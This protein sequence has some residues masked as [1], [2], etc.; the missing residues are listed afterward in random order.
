MGRWSRELVVSGGWLDGWVDGV[1]TEAGWAW[2][3]PRA[4][5]GGR[6][7]PTEW[8]PRQRLWW[9]ATIG[10]WRAG[11]GWPWARQLNRAFGRSMHAAV[12]R[13]ASGTHLLGEDEALQLHLL[14][15]E[16]RDLHTGQ[17]GD[18]GGR[19]W[20]WGCGGMKQRGRARIARMNRRRVRVGKIRTHVCGGSA[21]SA[22]THHLIRLL[23]GVV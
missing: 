3:A 7:Q 1:A 17:M 10:P 5:A 15:Q 12:G 21:H 16:A 19:G 13:A 4:N 2:L 18:G 23:I 6:T 22:H 20:V 14:L 8:T 11:R 9:A